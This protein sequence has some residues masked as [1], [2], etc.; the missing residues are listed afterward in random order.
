M[1]LTSVFSL[2]P[3][4]TFCVQVLS[5]K[6]LALVPECHYQ[7]GRHLLPSLALP[8]RGRAERVSHLQRCSRVQLLCPPRWVLCCGR[9]PVSRRG[10]CRSCC[11]FPFPTAHWSWC[12]PGT[13]TLVGRSQ[14]LTADN[15]FMVADHPQFNQPGQIASCTCEVPRLCIYQDPTH[16]GLP[17][18]LHCVL[19]PHWLFSGC[20][21]DVLFLS[22][23]ESKDHT[24]SGVCR[25][26]FL[27]NHSM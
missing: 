11:R 21:S 19:R 4:V 13:D 1:Q 27:M 17:Q 26:L 2:P 12:E 9:P 6:P 23:L 7:V 10:P 16:P 5:K 22:W 15:I 8:L 3:R 18:E 20:I 25:R 24:I 14:S